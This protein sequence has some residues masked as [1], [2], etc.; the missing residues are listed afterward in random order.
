MHEHEEAR[1][2]RRSLRIGHG[3]RAGE[4][5]TV[6]ASRECS[7]SSDSALTGSNY[8]LAASTLP[9]SR[10]ES[11]DDKL[12]HEIYLCGQWVSHLSPKGCPLPSPGEAMRKM[13]LQAHHA[14]TL[15][16]LEYS[17]VPACEH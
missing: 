7:V 1:P 3:A 11:G 6:G 15:G 9:A 4:R 8:R 12:H 16:T 14:V 17:A 2:T 5:Y 10:L 13:Q